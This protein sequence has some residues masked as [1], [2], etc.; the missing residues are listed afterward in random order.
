MAT[1]LRFLFNK[2]MHHALEEHLQTKHNVYHL[3]AERKQ[4]PVAPWTIRATES[5]YPALFGLEGYNSQTYPSK[6]DLLAAEAREGLISLLSKH[7]ELCNKLSYRFLN[8]P[9]VGSHFRR[10]IWRIILNNFKSKLLIIKF[11]FYI[12]VVAVDQCKNLF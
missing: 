3:Q 12:I 2:N 5:F 7:P 10:C 8:Q 9:L 4:E 11:K 1:R 6:S